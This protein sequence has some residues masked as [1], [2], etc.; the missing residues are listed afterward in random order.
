MTS[1]RVA[2]NRFDIV[3]IGAGLAGLTAAAVALE[4]SCSVALV[5]RG[6][7][8]FVLGSGCIGTREFTALSAQPDLERALRFFLSTCAEA[9]CEMEGDSCQPMQ[10]PSLLG[11]FH[12]VAYAPQT[13]AHAGFREHLPTLIAGVE[14]L[15]G[16]D[17]SFL[18]SRLNEQAR[19]HGLSA[20]YAACTVALPANLGTPLTTLRIAN[21]FD[22][23][24]EFRAT[25]AQLLR[26]VS[27]GYA[28]VLVPG[29]LG[30][31][32]TGAQFAEFEKSVGRIIGELPTLPPSITGLRMYNLLLKHLRSKGLEFY[33]GYSVDRI[34]ASNGI[35]TGLRIASPGRPFTLHADA[36]IVA[37]MQASSDLLA[38]CLAGCVDARN[39]FVATSP[40]ILHDEPHVFAGKILA[41]YRAALCASAERGVYAVR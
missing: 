9:G 4:S 40:S 27:A 19:T 18:A 14:S 1:S 2:S 26:S 36:I 16:F 31:Q 5:T 30:L 3:V 8:S 28:R 29:I 34:E 37:T 20:A 10:L 13:L 6:A 17:A 39:L 32:A 33:E 11:G 21:V 7:G 23:D 22:R 38:G 25:L 35:C 41:G 24:K 12:S 15:S